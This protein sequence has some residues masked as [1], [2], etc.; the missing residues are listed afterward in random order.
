MG[1]VL[2]A[3]DHLVVRRPGT[4]QRFDRLPRALDLAGEAVFPSEGMLR[5]LSE[6]CHVN[7]GAAGGSLIS[8]EKAADGLEAVFR[9]RAEWWGGEGE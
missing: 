3:V 2:R 6:H 9:E 8:E 1:T 5:W 7:P 4:L